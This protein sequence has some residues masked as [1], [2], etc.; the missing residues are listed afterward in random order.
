METVLLYVP[1]V[2]LDNFGGLHHANAYVNSII[3]VLHFQSFEIFRTS[4]YGHYGLLYLIPVKCFEFI[5]GNQWL[6]IT[7]TAAMFGMMTFLAESWL[8]NKLI[9]N[10]FIYT[11]AFLANAIVNIQMLYG[12]YYQILPQRVL[13]PA[14]VLAGCLK[15][16]EQE[17]KHDRRFAIGMWIT[18][19]ISVIWNFETGIVCSLVWLLTC[20]YWKCKK[21]NKIDWKILLI[22]F[23]ELFAELLGSYV[24][25]NIYNLL[26]GGTWNSIK[27]FIYPVASDEYK[28]IEMLQIGLGS[29][30]IGYFLL[31]CMFT[32]S[33]CFFLGM[34]F[35]LKA[36][37][38]QIILCAASVM[39]LGL[40][41]YYMNRACHDNMALIGFEFVFV[42]VILIEKIMDTT[43]SSEYSKYHMGMEQA[44]LAFGI[45]I[46]VSMS[47]ST[48][49]SVPST[50]E[51]HTNLQWNIANRK[52]YIDAYESFLGNA[53][54]TN[55]AIYGNA[56]QS[57]AASLDIDANIYMIDFEDLNPQGVTYLQHEIEENQWRYLWVIPGGRDDCLPEAL[58]PGC[59]N[60]LMEWSGNF[61]Y[62]KQ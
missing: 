12:I 51:E 52:E 32:G 48:I 4:I 47:I 43:Q 9:K 2:F 27:E 49:G 23:I 61:L 57:I 5:L 45:F 50:M 24:V 46:L 33:I 35:T 59:Y 38:E 41:T 44:L 8:F 15:F 10:D 19:M 53:S 42:L 62:E 3:N 7:A 20:I 29:P 26:C 56:A 36:E 11:M 16:M 28:I 14:L 17:R 58:V 34:I 30:F 40:Y 13:F 1:N 54:D 25:V 39:G 21:I 22:S 31:I 6:A 18:C 37:K 60:L 55:I